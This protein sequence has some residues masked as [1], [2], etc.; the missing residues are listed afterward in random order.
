MK[1]SLNFQATTSGPRARRKYLQGFT[2]IELLVVIAIIAILAAIL[3]PVFGRARENAR[4]ASCQSNLKQIGLGLMQYVQ[5]NNERVPVG[6]ADKG[7]GGGDGQCVAGRDVVWMSAIQNYVKSTEVFTCPSADFEQ[8]D[9]V[10]SDSSLPGY[11]PK[12]SYTQ[13]GSYL[14][15]GWN[16]DAPTIG[17]KGP[18]APT[19]TGVGTGMKLSSIKDPSRTIWVG[20]GNG[21]PWFSAKGATPP[22]IDPD[23]G[24][25]YRS[26][27]N[28]AYGAS[29]GAFIERH[30][31]TC[32][33]LYG[34]GHVKSIGL[35][36]VTASMLTVGED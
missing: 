26:M 14:M 6:C 3:F 9:L 33:F 16:Y 12:V 10:L 34:D 13:A 35:D 30:L 2:L 1:S 17:V 15:N 27:G 4:R 5:D 24:N 23:D 31:D 21:S 8:A 20:D 11:P 25:G 22:A 18:G 32:S 19:T 7:T 28:K 36:K 29:S